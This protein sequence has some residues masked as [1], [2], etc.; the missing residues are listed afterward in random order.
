MINK[1]R[2]QNS[3]YILNVGELFLNGVNVKVDDWKETLLLDENPLAIDGNNQFVAIPSDIGLQSPAFFVSYPYTGSSLYEQYIASTFFATGWGVS[4]GKSGTGPAHLS[5]GTFGDPV[6]SPLIGRIYNRQLD[7][8]TKNVLTTFN[9]NSGMLYSESGFGQEI[10]IPGDSILGWDI[11]SGL[12]NAEDLNVILFGRYNELYNKNENSGIILSSG[13]SAISF[14]LDYGSVTGTSLLEYY[15]SNEFIA[16]RWGIYT[17]ATGS[18]PIDPDPISPQY[19]FSG[20]FYYRD[21]KSTTK[22]TI[23]N[24]YLNSGRY[25][26]FDKILPSGVPIPFRKIIGVDIYY[27]LYDLKNL[28]LVLGGHS[29]TTANYYRNIVTNIRLEE[30]SGFMVKENGFES[31]N[32]IPWTGTGINESLPY[33]EGRMY[34]NSGTHTYNFNMDKPDVTLNL[35][36][37][38]YLRAVNKTSATILNGQVVYISG[39]QGNRPKVWLA[40]GSNSYHRTHLIGVATHNIPDN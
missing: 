27:G 33:Q 2:I 14:Y 29:I 10:N 16:R 31:I 6:M 9:I 11:I 39:S 4:L 17:S 20:R 34:Y 19:P 13:D 38:Q 23:A 25:S 5:Q 15:S 26:S 7:Q 32:M 35:G 37:E 3:E 8:T 22:F 24:F 40:N 30:Y 18:A 21:P 12:Q 36:Q 1:N 28:H